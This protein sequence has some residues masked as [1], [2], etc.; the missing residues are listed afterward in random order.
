MAGVF[1][2][3][4]SVIFK[5]IIGVPVL[6]FSCIGFMVVMSGRG[7]P[8]INAVD[9]AGDRFGDGPYKEKDQRLKYDSKLA[10]GPENV[11][12]VPNPDRLHFEKRLK[13]EAMVTKLEDRV[14]DEVGR[15]LNVV[16]EE[17][18]HNH[19]NDIPVRTRLKKMSTPGINR[20][21]LKYEAEEVVFHLPPDDPNGPGKTFLA[22]GYLPVFSLRV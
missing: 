3:R 6:W 14:N 4:R 2:R 11:I 22:S 1:I 12:E 17:V 21:L 15:K 16:G 19:D 18:G 10:K 13:R 9:R 5:F 20:T 7:I 8:D